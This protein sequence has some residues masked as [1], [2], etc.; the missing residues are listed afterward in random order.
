MFKFVFKSQSRYALIAIIVLA[1]LIVYK[2]VNNIDFPRIYAIL[3]LAIPLLF[4]FGFE[5]KV[6][7]GRLTNRGILVWLVS[8]IFTSLAF[9]ILAGIFGYTYNILGIGEFRENK[10]LVSFFSVVAISIVLYFLFKLFLLFY[11]RFHDYNQPG[12][13]FFLG[14][15]PIVCWFIGVRIYKSG[16]KLLGVLVFLNSLFLDSI[17]FLEKSDF[18]LVHL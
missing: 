9:F 17:N 12:Y 10:I 6:F 1:V 4:I 16:Q 18:L 11:K 15:L 3:I 5:I 13:Y 8:L 2:N 7:D 14:L